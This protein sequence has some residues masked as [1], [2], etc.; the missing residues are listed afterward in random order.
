MWI[1]TYTS[2][3]AGG[4]DYIVLVPRYKARTPAEALTAAAEYAEKHDGAGMRRH[5][6]TRPIT[7]V[8]THHVV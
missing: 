3:V 6:P 8:L 5:V 2:D 1:V 4:N 7:V